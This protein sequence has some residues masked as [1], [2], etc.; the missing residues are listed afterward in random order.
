MEAR[1]A[2]LGADEGEFGLCLECGAPGLAHFSLGPRL[3]GPRSSMVGDGVQLA[4]SSGGAQ[5][6]LNGE[7]LC[8][9][10]PELLQAGALGA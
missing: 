2:L 7:G 5:L 6:E 9:C 8:E 1:G 10:W 4:A 3:V